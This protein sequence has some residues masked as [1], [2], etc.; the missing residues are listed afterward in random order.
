[1]E[2]RER[3]HRPYQREKSETVSTGGEEERD[4]GGEGLVRVRRR[5]VS[6]GRGG[7]KHR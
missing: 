5:A 3:G 1:M 7:A 6:I 2:E 4:R